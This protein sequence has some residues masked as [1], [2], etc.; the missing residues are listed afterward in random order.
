MFWFK[1]LQF[2]RLN[3]ILGVSQ[4]NELKTT[5]M[6]AQNPRATVKNNPVCQR[7]TNLFQAE[8]HVSQ[9]Q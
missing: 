8:E 3:L 6:T 9:H 4:N 1:Q 7:Q 5:E 2:D